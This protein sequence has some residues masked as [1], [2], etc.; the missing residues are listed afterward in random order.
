MYGANDKDSAGDTPALADR[1]VDW[2]GRPLPQVRRSSRVTKTSHSTSLH[3]SLPLPSAVQQ[4][5]GL[6]VLRAVA[7][8]VVA[9]GHAGLYY[10]SP[11]HTH[12]PDLGV[13]GIDLFFVLSGFILTLI[14]LRTRQPPGLRT[15][16]QFLRRRI[17]RIYPIYWVF[18]SVNGVIL[19]HRHQL[20]VG[21]V[22]AVLLL[23][24]PRYPFMPVLVDFTWTLVF[25]MFFYC[26]LAF[27]HLFTVRRAPE[28]LIAALLLLVSVRLAV[29]IQRPFLIVAAN[30]MLLEFAFGATIALLQRAWGR[31]AALGRW[32]VVLGSAATLLMV[33][34][35]VSSPTQQMILFDGGVVFRVATWGVAAAAIVA[36]VVFWAGEPRGWLGTLGVVL[37]NASYSAYLASALTIFWLS[38][39][40][41]ATLLRGH[42]FAVPMRLLCQ[43]LSVLAV[44]LVGFLSYQRVEWPMLRALQNRFR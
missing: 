40:L 10:M 3:T 6:Q 37:G 15:A 11:Q 5:D 8:T 22:Q 12:L 23:P 2:G 25:E 9:W 21:H 29:P 32:L 18:A 34:G 27:I 42:E 43:C 24:F 28:V 20:G 35:G 19:W 31:R 33:W 30:P 36:G 7:V 13:F 1:G 17:L 38:R 44:L 14:T 41:H 26:L 4:I 39:L 16:W